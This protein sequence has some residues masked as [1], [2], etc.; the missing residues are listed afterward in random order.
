MQQLNVAILNPF[1]TATIECL[2]EFCGLDAQRENLTIKAN[3]SIVSGVSAILDI[4]GKVVGAVV[5]TMQVPVAG[6]WSHDSAGTRSETR[7]SCTR[8]SPSFAT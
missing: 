4:H 7:K 5:L 3:P 8:A 1:L 2:Q 6:G